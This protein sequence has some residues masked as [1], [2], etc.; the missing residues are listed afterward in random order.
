MTNLEKAPQSAL[1]RSRHAQNNA[2]QDVD[3]HA[4]RRS[5]YWA[6]VIF[7]GYF[8]VGLFSTA[9]EAVRF[10]RDF[11]SR[12]YALYELSSIVVI[13]ALFPLIAR[14][15]SLFTPGDLPW[16]QFVP[17]HIGL[18]LVFS[19]VHIGAM[20][21]IRKLIYPLLSPGPYV[22]TDNLLREALYEYRKDLLAYTVLVF[23]IFISRQLAQQA[24]EIAAARKDAK[25]TK[26]LTLKC[27]GRTIWVNG[28]DVV[29]VKSAANYVEVCANGQVHLARAT[30]KALEQQL[31]EAGARAARV[32]RSY[33]INLDHARRTTPNGEGDLIVEMADSTSIPVSRRYRANIEGTALG[34]P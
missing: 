32:H 8:L 3:R 23:L 15:V 9:T 29:W 18:S 11:D 30:L 6:G 28:A 4:D 14:A 22:F 27:G 24:L 26:R 34:T 25:D 7:L 33:V 20:V 13:L 17:I 21:I 12:L 31:S 5:L 2:A 10:E 16:R 1:K 19:A